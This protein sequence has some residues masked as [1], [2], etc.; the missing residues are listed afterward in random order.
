MYMYIYI[1]YIYHT[2]K[3]RSISKRRFLCS[4]TWLVIIWFLGTSEFVLQG[5][6]WRCLVGPVDP[7]KP[8]SEGQWPDTNCRIR[9]CPGSAKLSQLRMRP[10]WNAVETFKRHLVRPWISQVYVDET[11]AYLYII[12]EGEA[13]CHLKFGT[14]LLPDGNLDFRNLDLRSQS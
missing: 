5:V 8:V 2:S 14:A 4:G 12:S 9:L 7:F 13:G 1:I 11:S 3:Y 6:A 10:S